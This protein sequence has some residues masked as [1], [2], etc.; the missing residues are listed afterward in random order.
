[1]ASGSQVL[2]A[3]FSSQIAKALAI[4]RDIS[5]YRECGLILS[6]LESDATVVV[7]WI[8]EGSHLDSPSGVFLSDVKGLVAD[9]NGF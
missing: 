2:K 9:L 3:A 7:K 1:M 8:N 5:F 6:V 4:Y